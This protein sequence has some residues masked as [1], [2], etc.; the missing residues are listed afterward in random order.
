MGKIIRIIFGIAFL[1]GAISLVV[2]GFQV[3][4]T[5]KPAMSG[6]YN[7]LMSVTLWAVGAGLGLIAYHTLKIL[8]KKKKIR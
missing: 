6:A 1:A 3:L 7:I 8:K 2:A 4:F 5:P